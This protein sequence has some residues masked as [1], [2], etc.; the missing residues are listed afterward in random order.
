M[1]LETR[2]YTIPKETGFGYKVYDERSNNGAYSWMYGWFHTRKWYQAAN[3]TTKETQLDNRHYTCGFHIFTKLK[4]AERFAIEHAS[5]PSFVMK[6]QYRGAH[7]IGKQYGNT[8]VV[9]TEMKLIKR[10][11][12]FKNGTKVSLKKGLKCV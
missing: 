9:A 3:T 1:C 6:V 8:A 7:T 2:E 12:Q 10:A 11:S 4:E 5:S